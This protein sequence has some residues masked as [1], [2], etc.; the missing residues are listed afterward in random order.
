MPWVPYIF[1]TQPEK[2]IGNPD[3]DDSVQY[4]YAPGGFVAKNGVLSSSGSTYISGEANTLAVNGDTPFPYGTISCSVTSNNTSD[5]GIVFRVTGN[6]DKY[7][8]GAGISY[9]FYFISRD[10]SAYLGKADNG[11][12]AALAV[13]SSGLKVQ[14]GTQ[15]H[16]KVIVKDNVIICYLNNK[17]ML[18]YRDMHLLPGTAY[19]IRSGMN[20][21]TFGDFAITNEYLYQ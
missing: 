1:D 15:Y 14:A 2:T 3:Y 9:Y 7:W 19:G 10:G 12:W 8:E 6:G 18:T 17:L 20:G 16:L 21:A 13:I 11:A 4:T 5:T